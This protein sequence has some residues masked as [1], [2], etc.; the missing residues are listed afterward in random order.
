MWMNESQMRSG[1]EWSANLA[2]M[3]AGEVRRRREARKM[4]AQQ[5]SD[6]CAALGYPIHRSV[7]ANFEN[8][9][10]PTISVAELLVIARALDI[11]PVLLLFPVGY[12][13]EVEMLPGDFKPPLTAVSWVAGDVQRTRGV[14]VATASDYQ[15]AAR[16][17]DYLR[18][19]ERAIELGY[20]LPETAAELRRE[21]EKRRAELE[22]Q[23]EA[24]QVLEAEVGR[25][26]DPRTITTAVE[27]AEAARLLDEEKRTFK[28]QRTKYEIL[29][30]RMYDAEAWARSGEPVGRRERYVTALRQIRSEMRARGMVT[31]PLS[32]EAAALVG[33]EVAK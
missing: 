2:H 32:N 13:D 31:L 19:L 4:S 33:E 28:S 22:G 10:R 17:R 26:S 16:E 12:A 8:G 6:A 23:Y 9:R 18:E 24:L 29:E 30:K 21:V 20:H 15:L 7:L 25:L 3:I 27:V 11:A 5:L 14:D 1:P